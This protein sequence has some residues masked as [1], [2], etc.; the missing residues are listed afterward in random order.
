MNQPLLVIGILLIVLAYLVG[1]KKQNWLLSGYNQK[2]VKDQDKLSKLVGF[3]NLLAGLLLIVGAF[4]NHPD[5]EVFAPI[6]V[7]GYVVLIG[8]VNTRMVE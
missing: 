4:I 6:V 7:I 8:Y 1:V 2:R 3:Y 5:V